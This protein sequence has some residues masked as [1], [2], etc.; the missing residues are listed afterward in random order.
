MY[1]LILFFRYVYSGILF[2]TRNNME[3]GNNF[4]ISVNKY[5]IDKF[6]NS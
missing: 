3:R 2:Q 5:R 6:A 4:E 1:L